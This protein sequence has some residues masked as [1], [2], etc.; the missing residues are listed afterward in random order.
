[1]V[2]NGVFNGTQ[3][4][5]QQESV[6]AWSDVVKSDISLQA[7]V[8]I[9]RQSNT[10]V[11]AAPRV[12]IF[13]HYTG[14]GTNTWVLVL[15]QHSDGSKHLDLSD[16]WGQML[17][18]PACNFITSAWYTFNMTVH[19]TYATGWATTPGQTPCP[20]VSGNFPNSSPAIS[21]TKFGLYAGGYSA[22]FDDVQVSTVS[23]LITGTG[24]SNSFFQNGAPG[25]VGLNT[26][27]ATTKPP[28]QGW[29]V[30]INWL[31]ASAWSLAYPSQ[32]Y[33]AAP[34][35]TLTGWSDNN[36]QWIWSTTNANVSAPLGPVW[37]RRTFNVSATSAINVAIATDDTYVVYLD[38][39]RLGTG[40]NWQQVGSYTSS[41][42]PGYH[43]LAIN[44][45]NTGGPAGLLLS[46]KN[47]GTGQVI[48]RS[49]ATA[50]PVISALA[51]SGQLQNGASSTPIETYYSYYLWGG[52]NQTK[53][54]YDPPTP[55]SRWLTTSNIYDIYGNPKKFADPRGN[56]T[57][58]SFSA[59]YTYAYLTNQTRLDGSTKV[60]VLYAYNFTTG[61]ARIVTDPKGNATSY[62]NDN[63]GRVKKETYPLGAYIQYTY[64]DPANYVEIT[65]ENASKTRQIYDGLARQTF[66]DRF[67]NGVSYSNETYS[68]NWQDNILTK[69]DPLGSVYRFAYDAHGRTINAT[70]PNGK[71]TPQFYNDLASSV[72]TM[73][74]DGNNR[75]TIYDRLG[76]PISFVEKATADCLT[77]AVTKYYYNEVGNLVNV[78]N[79]LS[80]STT[81]NYDNLGRLTK[82]VYPDN[83]NE[84]YT[85]DNNGNMVNSTDRMGV[86]TMRSYDSLNRLKT[87]TYCGTPGI[88]AITGTS[89]TY[90]K[91]GNSLQMKNENATATYIYDARNRVLNETTAVNL[92]NRQ[93]VDLGCFGS[94]GTLTRNGGVSKTYTVGFTYKGE[95]LDTL[96]YP[97]ISQLNPDITIRYAYDG[98][99]RVLNVTRLGT[100]TY[101]GRSFTYY[102]NDQVKGLQFGNGLVGNY[103]YDNLS[104]PLNMT[105]KNGG[106]TMISLMYG[107]NN[108][109]TV[110]SVVGSIN[111]A[112]VNEQYRY[113]VLQRLTNYTVT[114]SGSATSGWYEY[115]NLG[116]RVRQK[117]NSTITSYA[118]NSLNQLT[119]STA[120]TT[121]QTKINYGYDLNGNLK[122]Q[123]V[124][125]VGTIRWTYTWNAA[126][127][128][129]RAT[130][131]TGQALYAYDGIGRMV[132]SVEGSSTWFLAYKG[133]EI[134]Y[135]N[136]LNQ[137]NQ[138]YVFAS[139]LKLVRVVDRTAM[140]YYHTDALGSTRMITYND[141]T[142]VFIDNYQPFGKVNGTP[143]G[144]LANSEKDRFTGKPYST[145]TGLYYYYQR[146]YDPSI[147]RF[148]SQDPLLGAASDPQSMNPYVY[149]ENSPTNYVD[150]TGQFL[151][152]ALVG[153]VIGAGIGYFGCVWATG[154]WGSACGEAALAGAVVGALAGLTYGASLAFAGGTLGL[155][156]ATASGSFVFSGASGLAAFA[157][158]GAASGAVAGGAQ[159]LASGGITNFNAQEFGNS[160]VLGALFGAATSVAGYGLG[161]LA[162]SFL[163][164]ETMGP[165]RLPMQ[166]GLGGMIRGVD[167]SGALTKIGIYDENGN[168]GARIDVFAVRSEEHGGILNP[169][170]RP[171]SWTQRGITVRGL[172]G[173]WTY[174]EQAV[175]QPT[176]WEKL[177]IFMLS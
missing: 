24:F 97:T 32:N 103:T 48:I 153:A 20:A 8:Y 46:V 131:G 150:P 102:K 146:W 70:K 3:T 83:R 65:N 132:E 77:G 21:G 92:A 118:Y 25:P 111:G 162:G 23:P 133:T 54:R 50:G 41:V 170:V 60:T 34:W 116:N 73:D 174:A 36:A 168:L 123:N 114:S 74:E 122:T 169:N 139:G 142:Y 107:Y 58:Y 37:F 166:N 61:N 52:L 66:V 134:L 67:L 45:T 176:Y 26:W 164:S 127:R 143:T 80:R 13:T 147:G 47:T 1:M 78:T 87:I 113:D 2:K 38:G 68:F 53:Q 49:D 125:T 15:I 101:Y 112:T 152:E 59:N 159:Y 42:G 145:A 105:L 154:D 98:L 149:V 161:K 96:M 137:N 56:T 158:A 30:S 44:A 57:Y 51:G 128:L 100:S 86:K 69:T 35:G 126:N 160:V 14:S 27:L 157:F 135:R 5:E 31:P 90:D 173:G 144:N 94:G 140:Y 88:T 148:I 17:A 141:A 93:V 4:G 156:T 79:S 72:R 75:C 6:F 121:P 28:S 71:S 108:T 163:T 115:D 82:T 124:T 81:Y 104:R 19:G 84:I 175:R 18:S 136:L 110:K 76:R 85:Y 39:S 9:T 151:I 138:A 89:Y 117:L 16:E 129:L 64:N 12:G 167:E 95:Y 11:G 43:V 29:N 22:L 177:L 109:G 99:G 165:G 91:N 120:Y 172:T 40:N 106:T 10:T 33:G 130:N 62:Q 119:N 55:P 155:G 7:R 63:L 171:Y